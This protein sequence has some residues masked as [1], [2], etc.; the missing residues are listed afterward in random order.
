MLPSS[1]HG[2]V[3]AIDAGVVLV[4]IKAMRPAIVTVAGEFPGG[5]FFS[6]WI[7]CAACCSVVGGLRFGCKSV[8][9]HGDFLAKGSDIMCWIG[10]C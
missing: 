4:E 9:Q 3:T 10:D 2:S 6:H 1:V 7:Q 8:G 5:A